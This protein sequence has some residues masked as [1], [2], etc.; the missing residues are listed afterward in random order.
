MLNSNINLDNFPP[1]YLHKKGKYYK[2]DYDTSEIVL[3]YKNK[4][5]R[6]IGKNK[7]KKG[8]V[9]KKIIKKFDNYRCAKITIS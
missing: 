9:I 5:Y 1:N 7:Y 2:L 8:K 3:F 4:W 6:R